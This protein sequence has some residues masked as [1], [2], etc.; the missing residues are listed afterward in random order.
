MIMKILTTI[1]EMSRWATSVRLQNHR[2]A[3]IP[4]M[5]CLHEGHCALLREG[6]KIGDQL[7]LSI[8]VNPTQFG[9]TEDFSRYPR[10]FEADLEKAR[11]CGVD[12]VF[13]PNTE[14]M[15]PQGNKTVIDVGALGNKLCGAFRPGHFQGVATVVAK[16]FEIVQPHA[17]LFGEKDYQ[18]LQV[19]RKLVADCSLP[20][21]IV[22]CPIVREADGLAM[23]SRN[24]YLS[25]SERE[26]A[27]SLSKSLKTASD[28][29]L[30]GETSPEKI[31]QA[32]TEILQKADARID[33]VSLVDAATL[34]PL[35]TWKTPSVLAIA[36]WIGTTR[37]ID[38]VIFK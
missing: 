22:G 2:I 20:V 26:R 33:Y 15:Y 7:V 37:L 36:A 24:T 9:P 8:F 17:A 23:S 19:I 12:V 35:S 29:V 18:Q 13:A 34:D 5:G 21:E 31:T 14:E 30:N 28:M 16:L 10:T 6:R 32:A 27:L 25:P 4:T 3:F 1:S 38:N 11:A